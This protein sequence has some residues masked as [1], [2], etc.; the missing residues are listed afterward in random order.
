MRKT[1]VARIATRDNS[2]PRPSEPQISETMR[3]LQEVG[4]S[5]GKFHKDAGVVKA[6]MQDLQT[7]TPA[8]E[9]AA[10]APVTE[11]TEQM[12]Q[13]AGNVQPKG[14][15]DQL[16]DVDAE[17]ESRPFALKAS[18][19]PTIAQATMYIDHGRP[20]L[21]PKKTGELAPKDRNPG[22]IRTDGT[23]KGTTGFLGLLPGKDGGA[24]TEYS[25]NTNSKDGRA[26]IPSVVPTL[27]PDEVL[28]LH[29]AASGLPK[30][31][32]KL[33]EVGE[34]ATLFARERA[35]QGKPYFFDPKIDKEK[36][37]HPGFIKMMQA[38]GRIP[39]D[40]KKSR[41]DLMEQWGNPASTS[42]TEGVLWGM[43][44]AKV[45]GANRATDGGNVEESP[46]LDLTKNNILLRSLT[47]TEAPFI[48]GY[49]DS[50]SKSKPGVLTVGEGLTYI[51]DDEGKQKPATIEWLSQFKNR[52][53]MK[54]EL[55]KQRT[56]YLIKVQRDLEPQLKQMDEPTQALVAN[57]AFNRGTAKAK[58]YADSVLKIPDPKQR[59]EV[60]LGL[61][62]PAGTDKAKLGHTVA[63]A[64]GRYEALAALK[65]ADDAI[66]YGKN[67]E[68][69]PLRETA[70]VGREALAN[71]LYEKQ[72]SKWGWKNKPA[73]QAKL[74]AINL[75][76][77]A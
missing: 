76:F 56:R 10:E 67:W 26:I 66:T 72:H 36:E 30:N 63:V 59:Y 21:L 2:I 64:K 32:R 60:A 68:N 61:L 19:V 75:R 25:I 14:L 8:P 11:G 53:E 23:A 71:K 37:M 1:I 74:K 51:T 28:A 39:K 27:T 4:D 65:T 40:I 18:K 55:D 43:G 29:D 9:Q 12:A 38:T 52:D 58:E 7:R 54:A 42:E 15:Y 47:E 33:E 62:A 46:T 49:M 6:L 34:K 13:G 48:G 31:K 5:I 57:V 16:L 50:V 70:V 69:A 3:L 41:T 77:K 73:E 20:E 22:L 35:A 24:I 44:A 45:P 17:V